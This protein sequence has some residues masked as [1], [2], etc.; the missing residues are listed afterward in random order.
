MNL[1]EIYVVRVEAPEAVL[2]PCIM[3]LR[4]RPVSFG[5]SPIGKRTFVARTT[6]SRTPLS[7]LQVISSETPFE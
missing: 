5:P 2:H 1:V 7:A 6:S 3:C 4:E